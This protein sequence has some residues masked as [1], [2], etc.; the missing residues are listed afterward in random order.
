MLDDARDQNLLILTR[1]H[2]GVEG[3]SLLFRNDFPAQ[4]VLLK[5]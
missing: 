2:D 5:I 3:N 1:H 4:A